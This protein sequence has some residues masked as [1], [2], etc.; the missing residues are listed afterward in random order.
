MMF[1]QIKYKGQL[2]LQYRYF[3]FPPIF[4]L[5]NF[6]CERAQKIA[7]KLFA[8]SLEGLDFLLCRGPVYI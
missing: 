3:L 2:L 8:M 1:K 6:Q 5:L 7:R 4:C